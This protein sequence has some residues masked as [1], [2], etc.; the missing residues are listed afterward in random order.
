MKRILLLGAILALLTG[1][2]LVPNEYRSVRLHES[3]TQIQLPEAVEVHS[4]DELKDAI[5]RFVKAG[6]EEG[7]IR[8]SDY[9][10][11]VEEDLVQAVYDVVRLD[12]VGA[13]AVDYLNHDCAKIV[14]YYEISL[15]VTY[16]RTAREIASIQ[17]AYT[18]EQLRGQVERSLKTYDDHLAMQ[19]TEDQEYDIAAI[20]DAYCMANPAE[21]VEIPEIAVSVFPET[22]RQR[23]VE[24]EFLYEN[25]Y[26]ELT[27]MGEA[28]E[29]S[30]A[31]A[32][33]YIRY[34]SSDRDKTLLLYT[35]LTQR[36]AYEAQDTSTPVYSALCEGVADPLGLAQ[37]F[38]LILDRAGVTCH[39]VTG[40]LDGGS[41]YWNI[42]SDDGDYRHVDLPACILAGSGLQYETDWE[43]SR[44]YWN[45]Q[46]YPACVAVEE[47]VQEPAEPL[48]EEEAPAEETPAEEEEA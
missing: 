31:A 38:C 28:V 9:A 19:V 37:G 39:T 45:A 20:V 44:Y 32:A 47:P 18:P 23:I 14:N 26:D 43:M 10:G 24:V 27:R 3:E 1:C 40:L 41:H 17:Q 11:N 8:A 2:S 12:P 42:V 25:S 22:G 34:R 4:Y 16:R 30:V 33:E 13:Y 6:R 5:L 29:E 7:T 21:M 15:S 48:P 46:E 36:F 35:Y